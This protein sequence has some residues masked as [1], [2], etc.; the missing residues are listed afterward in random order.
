MARRRRSRRRMHCGG[1][2]A[3]I[4]G[5]TERSSSTSASPASSCRL[6]V[7]GI[8]SCIAPTN[9]TCCSCHTHTIHRHTSLVNCTH[10]QTRSKEFLFAITTLLI[11]VSGLQFTGG[12]QTTN[13]IT[14]HPNRIF[15]QL[16]L[17]AYVHLDFIFSKSNMFS[18][19]KKSNIKISGKIISNR[20]E[21][22]LD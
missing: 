19:R 2:K 8:A 1:S 22:S 17:I 4:K 5:A 20:A 16:I 14:C 9:A 21:W 6:L 3:A 7:L 11:L 18:Q 12:F 10:L 15:L 13:N